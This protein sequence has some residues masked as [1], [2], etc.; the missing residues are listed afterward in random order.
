[1]DKEK[2]EQ[3]C[4]DLRVSYLTAKEMLEHYENYCENDFTIMKFKII[5]EK[6]ARIQELENAVDDLSAKNKQKNENILQAANLCKE[7][8]IENMKLF[9]K[10]KI[11]LDLIYEAV[12]FAYDATDLMSEDKYNIRTALSHALNELNENGGINGTTEKSTD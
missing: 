12:K 9:G 6:D 8:M 4:Q 3:L 7:L 11:D 1:M 10:Q 5:P 2:I